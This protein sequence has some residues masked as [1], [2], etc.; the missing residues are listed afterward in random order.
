MNFEFKIIIFFSFSCYNLISITLFFFLYRKRYLAI[1]VEAVLKK[2]KKKIQDIEIIAIL[3]Q[4]VGL[5]Y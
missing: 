1:I 3:K 2:I 5:T 4:K